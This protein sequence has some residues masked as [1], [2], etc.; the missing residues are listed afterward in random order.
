MA[1]SS[2]DPTTGQPV[3]LDSDA[4]DPA[5]NP[6]QVAAYAA[7]VGTRL[8]GTTAERTAYSYA[9]EGLCWFDTTLD[10]EFIYNGSGWVSVFAYDTGWITPTLGTNWST[11]AGETPKYRKLGGILF[12]SGRCSGTAAAGTTIFTLPTGFRHSVGY[13]QMVW[14]AHSDGGTQTMIVESDGDVVIASNAGTTRQGVSLA[15]ISY[16]VG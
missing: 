11:Y 3:F 10:Q 14:Q 8:I 9:R 4:P 16:P 5:V 6:S 13:T 1:Y 2:L 15:A 12:L 7:Q